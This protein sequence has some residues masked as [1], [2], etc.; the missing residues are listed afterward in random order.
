LPGHTAEVSAISFS[1]DGK[2]LASSSL[3]GT[4]RV[5]FTQL[6]DLIAYAK[7]RVTRTLTTE[8]CQRYLHMNTCPAP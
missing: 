4:V 1:P 5:Y 2:Y 3:D 6:E 7:T 8:E